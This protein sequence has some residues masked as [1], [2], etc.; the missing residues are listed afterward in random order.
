MRPLPASSAPAPA[1]GTARETPRSPARSCS[2]CV[3]MLDDFVY[4]NHVC[5]VF[6]R[7]GLSL[8]DFL[9]RNS[10]RPFNI[11]IVRDFGQQLLRAVH[12]LHS[13]KLIHT[14]LKPENILLVRPAA[15]PLGLDALPPV[16]P[17][18]CA[19]LPSAR[20]GAP[21]AARCP[22]PT[23]KSSSSSGRRPPPRAGAPPACRAAAR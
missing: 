3:K 22:T 18:R 17:L 2:H 6:Q 21:P 9:R 11:D 7:L 5:M 14:D 19:C 12:F 23:T 8:Y 4:R 20:R 13:Q 15:G 10:Y 16:R 1:A